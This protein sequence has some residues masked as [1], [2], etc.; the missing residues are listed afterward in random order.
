MNGG[1]IGK[2]LD[3]DLTNGALRV[4]D[5]LADSR[6]YLGGRSLALRWAWEQIPAGA[7]AYDAENRV[8][9]TTGPLTGTL[10][11]TAGRTV[12]TSLS[13]RVYP[14]PWHTHSTL[15]GWFG[16]ELKYAGFDAV[17][18][19]GRSA[20][21]VILEITDGRARLIDATDLWGQDARQT[22][23][24]LRQ[25]LGNGAQVMAIGQ[26]GENLVRFATVQHAEENAAGHSGFGAVWGSKNLK[27]VAVRGSGGV[28]VA[29][30]EAL[31]REVFGLGVFTV[32]PGFGELRPSF[33]DK[34]PRPV[35][36]QAC[37]CNCVVNS[38]SRLDDGRRKPQACIGPVWTG[39][40]MADTAYSSERVQ[41]PPSKN[42]GKRDVALH[43][44]C[45]SLGL[46]LWF[47][48]VLQP[49]LI[50]ARQLG[51]RQIRGFAFDAEDGAWFESFMYDLAYRRGLGALFADDLRRAVDVLEDELPAELV[52]LGRELEFAFGFPAHRESRFWNEEPLPFWVISAMMYAS[53]SRDPTI[54]S[55]LSSLHLADAMLALK[56]PDL[57]RRQYRRLAEQVWGDADALE[58]TFEN[59]APVAIWSQ[60]QHMLIDSL[61]MCDF[62]FPQ[63][64]RPMSAEQWRSSEDI[65]GDLDIDRRLLAAVTG[66][67][68]RREDLTRIAERAF[69]TERMLLARAG[70][71]RD[72]EE[73]LAS[74]FAL[75]CR[76][77]GTRIDAAGFSRL[78]S[79]YYAARGW[80]QVR[81]WPRVEGLQQL[82]LGDMTAELEHLS[83]G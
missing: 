74:H 38:F 67:E 16:A 18:V 57:S 28:P 73:A 50:R 15:G 13:P 44:L 7:D 24:A 46:D 3:V 26:A 29:R 49:W 58:P 69:T 5:T 6:A 40:G 27:A 35:C 83:T 61:L 82:G 34:S 41:A 55:H 12:M 22:Q 79:E 33:A 32:S 10:A 17:I 62:A 72:M 21:P 80:D 30:P 2:S 64:M 11:P 59:K 81:G 19:H 4:R 23:L 66:I 31:L 60:H 76:A 14:R 48:L 63:L 42:F 53:E 51:V 37:T 20:R 70:R 78:L 77:D 68:Y 8:F 75:P 39:G 47:R 54:G 9:L 1:W 56:D 71:G 65:L 45:N 52:E 36:S 25:R 43:E